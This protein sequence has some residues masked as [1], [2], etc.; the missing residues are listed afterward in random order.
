MKSLIFFV[1]ILATTLFFSCNSS[2][3]EKNETTDAEIDDTVYEAPGSNTFGDSLLFVQN[4]KLLW[5]VGDSTR[6]MLKNP[7][8][9]GINTMSAMHI[10][11]LIN[12]N[13]DSIHLDYIKTSHDT[14]YVHIPNSEMLTERIGS[15]GALQPSRTLHNRLSGNSAMSM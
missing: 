12:S 1:I 3:K 9:A 15:T 4:K 8:E 6:L 10:I 14:I 5:Q 2:S 13:Y 7:K 11:E